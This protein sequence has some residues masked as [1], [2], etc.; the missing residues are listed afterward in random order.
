MKRAKIR[1]DDFIDT[2]KNKVVHS[3]YCSE[4]G[5]SQGHQIIYCP[6]CPNKVQYI[7]TSELFF[8]KA[9][10]QREKFT[11]YYRGLYEKDNEH[12]PYKIWE[13][14]II[15]KILKRIKEIFFG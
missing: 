11:G 6:N 10:V 1:I 8:F 2:L 13:D 15:P 9:T 14:E 4:C 5:H 12:I 7:E 3:Y